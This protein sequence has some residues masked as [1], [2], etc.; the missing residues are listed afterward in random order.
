MCWVGKSWYWRITSRR[1]GKFN[2]RRLFRSG[3]ES[4]Y[5]DA[6]YSAKQQQSRSAYCV[7]PR[8]QPK[9]GNRV[10]WSC[11]SGKAMNKG[12]TDIF[13]ELEKDLAA[14]VRANH[15]DSAKGYSQ[16]K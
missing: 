2:L 14:T 10:P 1:C 6:I 7:F 15:F 4:S 9:R 13:V 3:T 11:C 12:L 8:F 5:Q 16:E